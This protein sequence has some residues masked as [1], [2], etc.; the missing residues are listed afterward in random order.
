MSVIELEPGYLSRGLAPG[1]V[2]DLP[3]L[4]RFYWQCCTL[5]QTFLEDVRGC[6]GREAYLQNLSL[7]L[8]EVF[9]E[10]DEALS[11]RPPVA[12]VHRLALALEVG[13]FAFIGRDGQ[14]LTSLFFD[15]DND[16]ANEADRICA[17]GERVVAKVPGDIQAAL[18]ST[19]QRY[20]IGMLRAWS[21]ISEDSPEAMEEIRSFMKNL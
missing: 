6:D 17:L 15:G 11:G 21:K 14:S 9:Y 20:M 7:R 12:R 4:F 13:C 18:N 19:G 10:M 8:I 5:L 3:R 1:R 16:V 2:E